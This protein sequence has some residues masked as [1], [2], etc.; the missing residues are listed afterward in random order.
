MFPAGTTRI[1]K[2]ASRISRA[3]RTRGQR[4]RARASISD[5]GAVGA[6]SLGRSHRRGRFRRRGAARYGRDSAALVQSLAEGFGR[7]CGRA[8]DS[9]FRP[10]RK[11]LA[12]RGC[13]PD[14][15]ESSL[16]SA[17]RR[18]SEFAQGRWHAF[19]HVPAAD[20]P[21][22]HL[23]LRSRS[24]GAGAGRSRPRRAG[25]SIK[26]RWKWETICWFTRPSRCSEPLLVFGSPRVALIA[27]LPRRIPTS[28][29]SS[30]A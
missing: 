10:R 2:A 7:I 9:P 17:Q 28:P 29:P 12:Q 11:S 18:Q 21:L 15:G 22:R 5:R 26:R 1:S 20:E 6:Y 4:S 19:G 24:A 16:L 23:R 25:S 30:C 27:R 3:A 14:R 8:A 13:F